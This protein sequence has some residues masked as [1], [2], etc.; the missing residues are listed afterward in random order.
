MYDDRNALEVVVLI[1][2]VFDP[3]QI[4]SASSMPS[5]KAKKKLNRN[6]IVNMK[7][8]TYPPIKYTIFL[9]FV[10]INNYHS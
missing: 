6:V 2:Q 5:P 7:K 9:R 1:Q 8:P 3:F 4:K 10:A